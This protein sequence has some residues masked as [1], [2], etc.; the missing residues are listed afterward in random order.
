MQKKILISG[1]HLPLEG[2]TGLSSYSQ[3]LLK[4]VKSNK[5]IV[6]VLYDANDMPGNTPISFARVIQALRVLEYNS[7]KIDPSNL[8]ILKKYLEQRGG[9]AKSLLQYA[10]RYR[11]TCQEFHVDQY[12]VAETL[13]R[14]FK[15][16]ES[17]YNYPYLFSVCDRI[18]ALVNRT[19][20]LTFSN[21]KSK[22]DIVHLTSPIPLSFKDTPLVT[23]VHD[24]I[25]L[26]YPG[27]TSSK[28]KRYE[29]AHELA[30]DASELILCVS[31]RTAEDVQAWFN[32][33]DEK[34]MV[35][36]Q[37]VDI[38]KELID[39]NAKGLAFYLEKNFSLSV[40]GYF[41]F[42]GA[43]EPKKNIDRIVA[44]HRNSETTKPLLLIGANGWM[45]DR[46]IRAINSEKAI[47]SIGSKKGRVLTLGY[48]PREDLL[49]V[50]QGA[51]ALVFPSLYEGFGLPVLEAMTLG[52]PVITSK[53]GGLAEVAGD[54]CL[55]VDPLSIG[56]IATGIDLLDKDDS[57]CKDLK[58]RGLIQAE[59]FSP[60]KYHEKIDIA[61][62]SIR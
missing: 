1:N 20:K 22:P 15:N 53:M 23:T 57:V 41:V 2:G 48:L 4:A 13:P 47:S 31:Q 21:S 38:D 12:R 39:S 11:T 45:S 32:I 43:I 33:P 50:V 58:R 46:A 24:I 29:R 60:K 49:K 28:L 37:C 16:V 44:A 10:L 59:K 34:I 40:G 25:P 6:N 9:V 56:S 26:N 17:V 36:H 52:T 3:S 55:T 8:F 14:F 62:N 35:T 51:K 30:F 27:L 42:Y 19:V 5:H 54:A 18:A 61:Y 7:C